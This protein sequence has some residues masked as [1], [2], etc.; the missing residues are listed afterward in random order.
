MVPE[1]PDGVA[2]RAHRSL[3]SLHSMV[4]FAPEAEEELTGVGLRPGRMCYF[5]SRSAPM[6]AVSAGVTAATFYSFNPALVARSIPRAWTLASMDDILAARLRA[7]DRALRRMLGEEA[8]GSADV[9]EAARLA[10]TAATGLRPDGRPLYAAH[11]ELPWPAEPHLVLW[12][13]CTLLREHRG[14]GHVA[15]L[16]VA[17]VSGLDALITHTATGRGFTPAAARATRG[18]SDEEWATGEDGLR[19]RGLLAGTALTP[20]GEQVRAAV[21]A[22]TDRR[23]AQPWLQ[24]GE[25]DTARLTALGKQLTRT[26]LAAGA[27]PAGIFAAP[28]G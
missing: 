24:L 18:W 27:F 3:D 4:Y 6:G 21:E 2:V 19:E 16:L 5:A 7:A 10:R 13:A 17:G 8:V 9:A 20:A 26:V 23:A 28:R 22:D 15:A 14:D 12:H 1:L 11:A 25:A